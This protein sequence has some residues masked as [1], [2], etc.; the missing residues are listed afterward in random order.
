[1]A[2]QSMST[3]PDIAV[4]R[5]LGI[6]GTGL[7]VEALMSGEI[8]VY[9]E[10]TG[11]IA[12]A[13]LK[14]PDL[15]KFDDIQKALKPLG[16]Q[17]SQPLGFN[18][19][20]AIALSPRAEKRF[21]ITKLSELKNFP[22]IRFGFSQEYD[23]RTDGYPRLLAKLHW[24][25]KTPPTV[26]NHELAYKAIAADQID[27][28]DV[29]T[30]DAGIDDLDLTVLAD[31]LHV[32]PNYDA[33]FLASTDFIKQCPVCWKRLQGLAGTINEQK[34]RDLN[35]RGV[36]NKKEMSHRRLGTRVQEHLILVGIAF[37]F[38][39]IVGVPLGFLGFHYRKMGHVVLGLSGLI[40]TIPSLALFCLLIPFLGIGSIPAI[41]AL[42]LY[43]LLPVVANTVTGLR[44]IDPLLFEVSDALCLSRRQRLMRLELPLASRSVWSGLKTSTIITIG[45]ATL[46]ALIGAGGL[47]AP[48]VEGLALNDM[49]L[50]LMGAIP[51]AILA[52]FAHFIFDWLELWVV[53]KGL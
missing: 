35:S 22:S 26:M 16:L 21:H 48:I 33:V 4:E 43:A 12:Q 8:D 14:R 42:C 50:V 51:S 18:N 9:P 44:G 45:T 20:Y 40:Q 19:S 30:T 24:H 10:Y 36:L 47:G 3:L 25:P 7:V 15:E 17:M 41:A 13:I 53:P 28:M 39:L 11:T 38:S 37:F 6:G 32:T 27:A 46:A 31:D 49:T 52:L 34:M 1:M 29:Y 2:A 5:R 23:S